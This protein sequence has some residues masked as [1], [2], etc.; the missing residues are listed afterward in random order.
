[1]I[2]IDRHIP[3]PSMAE[4]FRVRTM[5]MPY[6][7]MKVGD[8]FFIPGDDAFRRMLESSRQHMNRHGG[9]FVVLPVFEDGENGARCWCEEASTH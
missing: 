4:R 3:I 2:R 6:R 8:S 7:T 5:R 9:R 1:M